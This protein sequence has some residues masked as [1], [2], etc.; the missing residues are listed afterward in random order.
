MSVDTVLPLPLRGR[1]LLSV[2]SLGLRTRRMRALL[3]GI[4]IAIGVASVVGVLGIST[5]SEADLLAKIGQ[6]SNLVLVTPG[7]NLGTGGNAELPLAAPSMISR[8]GLVQGVTSTALLSD[9]SL[10]RTDK[11]PS[12]LTRGISVVATQSNLLGILNGSVHTGVFLN[13]GTERYPAVVLGAVAA[14]RLGIDQTGE[15]VWIGNRWFTVV[16][17]LDQFLDQ[18]DLDQS[19]LIGFPEAGTEFRYNGSPSIIFV[20]T[21]PDNVDKVL[22]VL[23]ATTNPESPQEVKLSR[24]SDAL[25]ARAAA[26]TAFTQLFLAL[27]GVSL[28]VGGV[29]IANVMLTAVLERRTEI[30]L[31]RALGATKGDIAAQFLGEAILLSGLG[32]LAGVL[33]GVLITASYTQVQGLPFAVPPGPVAEA[34]AVA[35]LTGA[36]AGFYPALRAARLAPTEALGSV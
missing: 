17:I 6:L 31:R 23:A 1:D 16:G 2:A 7:Q 36:V 26:K 33:I 25:A 8:I 30:G 15:R 3:S 9:Q 19:A 32:G 13:A 29:M 22:N 11:E 21:D 20:R 10:Q 35:I 4:G 24:P 27:G 34:L 18:P 28:L 14:Q 5:A 12:G